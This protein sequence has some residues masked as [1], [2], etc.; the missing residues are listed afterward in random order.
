MDFKNNILEA[1][2]NTPLIKLNRMFADFD[3][4]TVLAKLETQNPG[5]S[6]KLPE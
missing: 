6:M 5:G 2:G 4:V 1:V 3:G